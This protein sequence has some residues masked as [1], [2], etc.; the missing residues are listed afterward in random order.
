M[1]NNT[2]TSA[3]KARAQMLFLMSELANKAEITINFCQHEI[4]QGPGYQAGA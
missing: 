1:V 4:Q 2:C 3:E